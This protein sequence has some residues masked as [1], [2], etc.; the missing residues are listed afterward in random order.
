V[1][2]PADPIEASLAEWMGVID[3]SA[4]DILAAA[5]CDEEEGGGAA[6]REAEDFLAD[7]LSVGP[8]LAKEV[9]RQAKEAA[10]SD[11]TLKR[12]KARLGIASR[13]SVEPGA[14]AHW[15]WEMPNQVK[16]A[17][18]AKKYRWDS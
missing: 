9:Q 7:V 10:I 18:D 2:L 15:A 8:I 5:E 6:L 16:G 4:R 3:G 17:K 12:A 13:R 11:R 14:S 1:L